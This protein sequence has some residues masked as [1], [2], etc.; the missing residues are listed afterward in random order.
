[1]LF[2]VGNV[3]GSG[4]GALHQVV[5]TQIWK[6]IKIRNVKNVKNIKKLEM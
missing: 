6:N 3:G 5:S 2:T 4:T 1:M